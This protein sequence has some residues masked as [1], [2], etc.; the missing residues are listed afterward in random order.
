[1]LPALAVEVAL[2]LVLLVELVLLVG[3]PAARADIFGP[4]SL[5]SQSTVGEGLAPPQQADYA[6]DAA[7]SG[8]GRYVAFDGS[9]GGL[10]GV[11][12]RDLQTGEVQPVAVESQGDPAIGAPDAELPSI[13]GDG[14]YVSFTTTAKLDPKDDTNSSPDVYVRDMEVP[15]YEVEGAQPCGAAGKCETAAPAG[16]FTLA[17]ARNGA[18]TGLAYAEP[19][20]KLYGSLAAGRSAI[21]ADGTQVAF[22]TTAVSNLAHPETEATPQTPAMQVAV[23]NLQTKATTLV[24]VRYDPATGAPA[25]GPEGREEPVSGVEGTT[26]YGAVF[27]DAQ[28]PR[29]LAPTPYALTPPVGASISADGS[30]VAW[31]GRDVGEQVPTLAGEEP[32]PHYAEPLW[33]RIAEGPQA[34]TRRVTG[35]AQPSAP[36]CIAS[37]ESVLSAPQ[38]P[39]DPCE[40]PFQTEPLSGIEGDPLVDT[41]PMLSGDGQ[42]VAFLATAAPFAEGS[43][44]IGAESRPSDLYV[45]NMETGLSR[46]LA[47]R[48]LTEIAGA[49]TENPAS[50]ASIVDFAIS[51][52]GSQVAFCTQR[53]IFPLGA[54]AYVSAPAASVGLAEL[55]DADLS[56][57]TITRVTRGFEGG[58]P[59]HPH[60]P[61]AAGVVPYTQFDGSLSPSFSAD[62]VTLAFSSTASNLVYGDGNTPSVE[63]VGFDGSDAFAVSRLLFG[64][65]PAPQEV[66]SAPPNP[67]IGPAWRLSVT[68]SSRKDGTVALYASVPGAGVLRANASAGV[69]LR[70]ARSARLRRRSGAARHRVGGAARHR[71]GR[72]APSSKRRPP[73]GSRLALMRAM[74]VAAG[75]ADP[76]SA[77]VTEL[78]LRLRPAY[79]GLASARGGLPAMVSVTFTDG[80]AKVL[81]A[82]VP[83]TFLHIERRGASRAKREPPARRASAEP[84]LRTG[85]QRR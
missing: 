15:V 60:K 80:N 10:T 47:L 48:P 7:I 45:S 35:G 83:V 5:A 52:D 28:P 13:S 44:G 31:M 37:G 67:G 43:F 25:V 59:E 62:G 4:I 17:S 12:R 50:D 65:D 1:M 71:A 36:A 30:T 51:P 6:H 82:L 64:S 79:G 49:D 70:S 68:A 29:M 8:D 14:R 19:A 21:S 11:W 39:S 81:R 75:G 56:D 55:F 33:R 34:L 3:P 20:S 58:Q 63:S 38:S 73:R 41:V 16:A 66:S 69:L 26:T 2:L 54:P 57:E 22:V 23:R 77:G 85:G 24:S 32:R 76:G 61:V 74:T 42:T 9:F 72:A 84:T 18:D 53:T 78:V 40:G 46:T 27:A